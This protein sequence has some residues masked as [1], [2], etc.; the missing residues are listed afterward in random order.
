MED[1]FLQWILIA[2]ECPLFHVLSYRQQKKRRKQY[3]GVKKRQT[4]W[5]REK[6]IR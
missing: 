5:R 3:G 4:E 2:V 6:K 1:F